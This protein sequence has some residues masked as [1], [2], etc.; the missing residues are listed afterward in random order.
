MSAQKRPF[1]AP[2]FRRE[3]ALWEQGY[4]RIAGVDEVG[5]GPLAGPVVAAAVL[6]FPLPL[7][8]AW[9]SQVRDSKLLSA[10]QRERLS[11]LILE[12]A[13]AV[14]VAVVSPLEIDRMGIGAAVRTAM[15]RALGQLPLKADYVLVDGRERLKTAVR[16]QSVVKG[17]RMVASIAAASIVAKVHRDRLM[18]ELEEQYPGWGFARHKGYGTPQHLEALRNL[19]P[20]PA[21]RR[22]FSP[23]RELTEPAAA[24]ASR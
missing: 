6:L 10:T 23:L 9:I 12:H 1:S 16:Q 3:M 22:S 13:R 8:G 11:P 2:D 20:S 5:R 7:E 17:D 24:A 4:R 21:H 18:A 14:A 19:G 15:A